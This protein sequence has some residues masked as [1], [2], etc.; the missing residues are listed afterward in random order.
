M[1]VIGPVNY[2]LLK[3]SKRLHLLLITVPAGAATITLLLFGYALIRDGLGTRARLRSVSELPVT[4]EGDIVTWSRQT[5]YAGVTPSA[6]LVYPR[7]AL[8]LPVEPSG[9]AA[10]N[11]RQ[12]ARWS[13]EQDLLSGYLPARVTSQFMVV[14]ASPSA[15]R[16]VVSRDAATG[17]VRAVNQLGVP[18]RWL[19]ACDN[20]Q[21]FVASDVQDGQAVALTP[22]DPVRARADLADLESRFARATPLGFTSSSY[23]S[24]R[25]FYSNSDQEFGAPTMSFS[26]L[27]G[28]ISGAMNEW[29][30]TDRRFV[31][32]SEV[33]PDF[34]P[35]GVKRARQEAGLHWIRG[36][37]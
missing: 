2:W 7:T 31:G 13:D 15:R 26:M 8:V 14:N 29:P 6:G 10:A 3:R 1:I 35:L 27:E 32:V 12:S 28:Q 36:A 22:I 5:Y 4:G 25:A 16:L 24:Y 21:T 30:T 11:R 23:R 37:W 19:M 18:L 34:V 17:S 9:E 33:A 20:G